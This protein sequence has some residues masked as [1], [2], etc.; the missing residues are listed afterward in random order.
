MTEFKLV[1]GDKKSGKCYQRVVQ[2]EKA[3]IFLGK[4]IGET[5]KGDTFDLKGFE[6][7][8]TG[9]ADYCG[10]PMRKDINGSVRKK[11]FIVNGVGTRS[12]SKG[13]RIR[14]TV[15]GNQIHENTTQICLKVTKSGKGYLD[16]KAAEEAAK[17]AEEKAAAKASK[18]AAKTEKAPKEAA[19]ED[20]KT[21]AK[22][23]KKPA[24]E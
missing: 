13:V 14:K 15:C 21:E 18:T 1:I 19:T 17:A 10:F 9:G 24:K 6:F 20:K 12:K 16:P 11:V 8:I 7:E 2:E 4:K 23:E 22:S 5:V 3:D